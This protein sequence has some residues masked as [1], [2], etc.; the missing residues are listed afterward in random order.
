MSDTVPETP[1]RAGPPPLC[2]FA[3]ETTTQRLEKMLSFIEGVRQNE[4]TEPVHQM[5]VWSRRT[6]AALE[7][8]RLCFKDKAFKHL[9]AEIKAAAD[10]IG[11]ARD[12]D[13]MIETMQKRAETLPEKQRPGLEAF[14]KHLRKQR[15]EQQEEVEKAVTRLEQH[16]LQACF[17]EIAERSV[18]KHAVRQAEKGD[19]HG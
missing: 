16:D 5:R 18:G 10:A 12:L 7:I 17:H 2:E 8:F 4:G 14:L 19:T 13:V 3:V 15:E 6:R 9:E 11:A 1:G